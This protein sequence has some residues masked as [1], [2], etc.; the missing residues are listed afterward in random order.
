MSERRV[1]LVTGGTRG[2]G[3]AI[4]ERLAHDGFVVA[5]GYRSNEAEA[6]EALAALRA[7][8]PRSIVLRA[9]LA[10]PEAAAQLVERVLVELGPIDALVNN[11]M[12]GGRVPL[13]TH[14]VSIEHWNDDLANNLTSHFAVTRAC[15]PS[16]M[17][18]GYGRI[19]FIG[20]LAMRGE[21]GRVAYTVAKNGLAGLAKTIAQEYAKYGITANVVNPGFIAA[22]AFLRLTEEIQE[23]ARALVPSKQTGRP[24]QVAALVAHL[25]SEE[26]G[27]T[28]GQ[29]IGVDGGAR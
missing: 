26:A 15:L 18:R 12:K 14:E 1:A 6:A 23:R 11:A 22:G 7:I 21:R 25:C 13:L 20:S 5:M 24:E 28:T 2:I 16:M 8:E 19:V 17:A 3:R 27:Y 4:A 9:D 10:R 29:V